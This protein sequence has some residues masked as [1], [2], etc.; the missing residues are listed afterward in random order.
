MQEWQDIFPPAL[1]RAVYLGVNGP[2]A[3]LCRDC[4]SKAGFQ[5]FTQV[6]DN[7][8]SRSMRLDNRPTIGWRQVIHVC[9]SALFGVIARSRWVG[10]LAFLRE[11]CP[12]SRGIGHGYRLGASV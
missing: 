2:F 6:V 12:E 7:R 5:P 10:E 8:A 9:D 3:P 4:V 11:T 1:Y